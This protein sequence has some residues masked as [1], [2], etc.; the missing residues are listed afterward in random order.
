MLSAIERGMPVLFTPQLISF[1]KHNPGYFN[2]Q[3]NSE[4]GIFQ[5]DN[6]PTILGDTYYCLHFAKEGLNAQKG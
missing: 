6:S 3:P 4:L 2:I 5:L 1:N